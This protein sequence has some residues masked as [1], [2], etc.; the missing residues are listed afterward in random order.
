MCR[1]LIPRSS[2]SLEGW[3]GW[4]MC[5]PDFKTGRRQFKTRMLFPPQYPSVIIFL[6]G[7][8]P[9]AIGIQSASKGPPS[10]SSPFLDEIVS[11]N[12]CFPLFFFLLSSLF[13]F[14]FSS[15][16]SPLLHFLALH[17]LMSLST[18]MQEVLTGIFLSGITHS[19]Y[20][21]LS[22]RWSPS[23]QQWESRGPFPPSHGLLYL[24]FSKH[25]N[26]C[27]RYVAP[28]LTLSET[29]H[30]CLWM[31]GECMECFSMSSL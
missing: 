7:C 17:T 28:N 14:F 2:E 21:L 18:D 19:V 22:F 10:M 30:G 9:F 16:S 4:Q 13:L 26:L 8:P 5:L 29:T 23:L 3:Q 20:C 24:L 15:P 31:R 11:G 6:S 25:W 12:S 1:V 27:P